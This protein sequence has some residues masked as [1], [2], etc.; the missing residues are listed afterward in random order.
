M[1]SKGKLEQWQEFYEKEFNQGEG[2]MLVDNIKE[3]EKD[4]EM[5]I[6]I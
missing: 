6:K 5:K 2:L 1:D 4:E 3:I